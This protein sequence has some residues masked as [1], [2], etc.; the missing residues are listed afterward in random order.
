MEVGKRFSPY[1]VFIGSF[2]PN[3]LMEY[4]GISPAAKLLW[5][6]LA[7]HAG[8]GGICYPAQTTLAKELGISARWVRKLLA[9]LVREQFIRI[10]HPRGHHKKLPHATCR[11]HFLWHESFD[12][13]RL[14]SDSKVEEPDSEQWLPNHT[15]E[16]LKQAGWR[17]TS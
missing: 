2:I 17:K 10:I 1:K 13:A 3:A 14:R 12:N 11:Y 5:A 8:K 15:L 6:R 9:E 7:Q 16:K 4:Q